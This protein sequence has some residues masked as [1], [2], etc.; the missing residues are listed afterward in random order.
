MRWESSISANT[1]DFYSGNYGTAEIAALTGSGFS[2][3]GNASVN[4]SGQAMH[5]IAFNQSVNFFSLGSYVGNGTSG[6]N[7]TGVGFEPE[8]VMTRELNNS[9][10]ANVKPESSGYNTD[11]IGNFI[12]WGPTYAGYIQALQSDGFRI[13]S[14]GEVNGNGLSY[15]YFAFKQNDAPLFVDTTSDS[16]TGSD[17]SSINALRASRGADGMISLRKRLPRPMQHA[18]S[19]TRPT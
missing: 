17:T 13:S 7:I 16:N 18:T 9:N 5:Y 19:T 2:V 11:A 10:W 12:G 14:D 4:Q 3:D 15:G 1:Y 8:F 6:R